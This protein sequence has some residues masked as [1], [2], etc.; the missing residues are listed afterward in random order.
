MYGCRKHCVILIPFRPPQ[1]SCF[2]LSLKCFSSDSDNCPDVGI[3]P[4]LQ[5]PHPLRVGPI[6]LALL[7]F[8]LVPSSYHFSH[9]SGSPVHPQLVFCM[10]FCVWRCIFDVSV[11][12]DVLHV[13]LL[14]H[15]LVPPP[16]NVYIFIMLL[17]DIMELLNIYLVLVG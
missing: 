12:R 4:L 2:T 6:L 10:H 16:C 1:I 3:G 14:L 17:R 13:Q 15:H 7:F 8:S 5:F 11:E 9:W